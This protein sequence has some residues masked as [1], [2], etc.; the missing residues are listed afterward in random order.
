MCL[1]GSQGVD[2]GMSVDLAIDE[3]T[4]RVF[5]GCLPP[6][7][8]T[9]REP[10]E[11]EGYKSQSGSSMSLSMTL[12]VLQLLISRQMSGH[13]CAT[14]PRSQWMALLTITTT[15]VGIYNVHYCVN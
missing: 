13:C 7:K 3:L 5:T 10:S 1:P 15:L 8:D 6:V 11:I 14:G 2:Y 9:P 4:N 12:W